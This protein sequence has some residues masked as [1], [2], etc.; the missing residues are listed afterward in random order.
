MN[1][2]IENYLWDMGKENFL[3]F[4]NKLEIEIKTTDSDD[5]NKKQRYELFPENLAPCQIAFFIKTAVLSVI[6]WLS[7]PISTPIII[8]SNRD[9]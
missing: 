8:I 7:P 9:Y 4:L 3:N 1:K 5:I 6:I 2:S